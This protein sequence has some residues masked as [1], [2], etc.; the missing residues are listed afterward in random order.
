MMRRAVASHVYG[1]KAAVDTMIGYQQQLHSMQIAIL[2]K[3]AT[4][5]GALFYG[6]SVIASLALGTFQRTQVCA[7]SQLGAM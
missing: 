6:S 2:G 3:S 7:C 5:D 1:V 4:L